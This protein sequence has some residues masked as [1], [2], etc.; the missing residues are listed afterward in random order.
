MKLKTLTLAVGAALGTLAASSVFA[1]GLLPTDYNAT[2]TQDFYVSGASAQDNGILGMARA[3]CLAG[4]MSHYAVSNNNIYFCSPDV[5]AGTGQINLTGGKTKMAIYKYSVG[6]SGSG[7]APV[8]NGSALPFLDL[9]KLTVGVGGNCVT[10]APDFTDTALPAYTKYSC[11]GS[12][13]TTN[14]VTKIGFSDVEP[15]FFAPAATT[16]LLTK[17]S[18]TSLIFGIPVSLKV[19]NKLQAYQGKTVG[20]ETEADMPSL[21]SAQ[22]TTIYTQAGQTWSGIGYPMNVAVGSTAALADDGIYVARR[23]N[24]SG[25]QKTFEALAARSGNGEGFKSCSVNTDPFVNSPNDTVGEP[26]ATA[27]GTAVASTVFAGS[28][29]SDVRNCLITH[30]ANGRGAV[31]VITTEEKP[32]AAAWRFVAID[33]VAPTQRNTASGAY[34]LYTENTFQ[35][36]S[37]TNVGNYALLISKFASDL[38]NPVVIAQLDSAYTQTWGRGGLLALVS[39]QAAP[40]PVVITTDAAVAASPIN[41]WTKITAS[42]LNNCQNPKLFN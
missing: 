30:D 12:N 23:V 41:P 35:Y 24:S 14:Q 16:A 42:G 19:R 18:V 6:G 13:I 26:F 40:N 31:G 37:A 22:L 25:T 39:N 5:G 32:G 3:L 27:C 38:N 28:G 21:T 34:R 36:K 8:A 9:T 33:G 4:T 15:E 1:A 29:G 7:I 17:K 2:T 10:V 11:A 20:G